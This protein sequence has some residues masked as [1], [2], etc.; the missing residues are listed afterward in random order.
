[1]NDIGQ[2]EL[3]RVLTARAESLV[4]GVAPTEAVLAGARQRGVRRRAAVATAGMLT[5][6]GAA[7]EVGTLGNGSA[8]T[9]A[10]STGHSPATRSSASE[11]G[12]AGRST[13]GYSFPP[14]VAPVVTQ[15]AGLGPGQRA[16]APGTVVASGTVGG[17]PWQVVV[18]DTPGQTVYGPDNTVLASGMYHWTIQLLIAGKDVSDASGATKIKGDIGADGFSYGDIN[19]ATIFGIVDANVA[20][21]VW[22]GPDGF[23]QEAVAIPTGFGG[24]SVVVF[25]DSLRMEWDDKFVG[26]DAAGVPIKTLFQLSKPPGLDYTPGQNLVPKPSGGAP[27]R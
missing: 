2:H 10:V 12:A 11:P 8:G 21:A 18:T 5:V 19:M 25:P 3:E 17:T 24:K 7:V 20:K 16:M 6:A 9:T 4:P 26:Y 14:R 15:Q 22:T 13:S 23:R 1:M 27:A